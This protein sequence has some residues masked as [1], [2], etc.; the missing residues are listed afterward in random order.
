[1]HKRI[2]TIFG[3]RPEAIK[4]AP[5]IQRL[6]MTP[7][8]ES[9][10]CVTAQHRELLDQVLRVF[11]IKP[12]HDLDIMTGKQDLFDITVKALAGLRDVLARERPD[13]VLVQGDTTT[14]FVAG[15]AAYYARIPLGHVEAGL[16]TYDKYSPFPEELNRRMVSVLADYHFAPTRLSRENLLKENIPEDRIWVTGNTVVDAL[17]HVVN[18]QRDATVNASWSAYFSERWGLTVP[19]ADPRHKLVL[20]TGHRRENFGEKFEHICAALG[21]L[22]SARKD[23]TIIY[24]VHLNPNIRGPVHA[25]LGSLPNVRL[26]EPLDYEPFTF[27]MTQAHL[28]LTDSGGIQEEAPSLGKPVLVMRDK[29]ERPEGIEAGTIR[30]VGTNQVTIVN[31]TVRLLDDEKL[32]AGMSTAVN[33]YGDGKAAERIV[34]I[35]SGNTAA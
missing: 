14:A 34:S 29:T 32:Y 19:P 22:A 15:L 23:I 24:P 16:R 31:E 35:I 28:I 21:R 1:M 27:L 12:D 25:L 26:I 9:R 8:M 6:A 13:L 4:L 3:T 7:G 2:L 11:S 17:M 20:V 30:M 5:V 10:V 18:R 33:P